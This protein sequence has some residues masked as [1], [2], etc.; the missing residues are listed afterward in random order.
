MASYTK[1]FAANSYSTIVTRT[2]VKRFSLALAGGALCAMISLFEMVQPLDR[3]LYDVIIRTNP[4]P[5]ADDIVIVAIDEGSLMEL[6]RWPWPRERHVQ[7]L[8]ELTVL[9]VKAIALDIIFSEANSDYPE[10]DQL[11][12]KAMRAHGRVLLPIFVGQTGQRTLVEVK[13]IPILAAAAADLGHVHIELDSDGASR[14]VYLFDGIGAPTW[15]HF[16]LALSRLTDEAPTELPGTINSKR[17]QKFIPKT[18]IRDYHNL[19]PFMGPADTVATIS[20]V[21]VLRGRVSKQQLQNKIVFVGATAAG[22]V[23]NLTTPLGQISGVEINAN[24][25]HALRSGLLI[26]Q[27]PARWLAVVIF[28]A[29]FF[30]IIFFT[31]LEPKALLLAIVVSCAVL[32]VISWLAL[33]WLGLWASP[34]PV[35]VSLILAYP[36]WNWSRLDAA[37]NFNHRQLRLLKQDNQELHVKAR[38]EDIERT[39]QFL[40]DL[41]YLKRWSLDK[42]VAGNPKNQGWRHA[43]LHSQCIYTIAEESRQL[44]LFWTTDS[45]TISTR[46]EE[47]FPTTFTASLSQTTDKLIQS[48]LAL[49][50]EAYSDASQNREL[51]RGTM[52]QLTTGIILCGLGGDIL[53]I[54]KQARALLASEES[55]HTVLDVLKQLELD[56]APDVKNLVSSLVINDEPFSHEGRCRA[57]ARELLCKGRLL[58]LEKPLILVTLTDVTD[59]KHSELK[60]AEALDFL[61]HDLR[62]PLTSVLALIE[63]AKQQDTG[64]VRPDVL[65]D[66]EHYIRKNLSYAEN[67]VQLSRLAHIEKPRLD[68]C[69][70]QSMVDNAVA[71]VYHSAQQQG[72]SIRVTY[73]SEDLWVKCN[74][75]FLERALINLIDNSVKYGPKGGTITV[76]LER[77]EACIKFI[78]AD[79]GPGIPPG[80]FDRIF[81]H[82]QQGETASTG[83]GLGLRFVAAVAASH[84]GDV[85]VVNLQPTGARFTLS[86]PNGFVAK[87]AD[88]TSQSIHN[89]QEHQFPSSK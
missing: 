20:Y 43:G 9:G 38:W 88:S 83:V 36:L 35:M 16:S 48:D 1:Y 28:L 24:I 50:E 19:I 33:S 7:L 63:S 60:R 10:V 52:E 5:Q 76:G 59:M 13:P 53:I 39:A 80:D 73:S 14:S 21:D 70:A 74:R 18:I 81:G 47:L 41:G 68:E 64:Q 45:E 49:L 66:I 82:F 30:T 58:F 26:Q 72:A 57:N 27:T 56:N 42:Y 85:K 29:T 77:E 4:L 40:H 17:P 69:E 25:F 79:E 15:P 8:R 54:N 65:E 55:A 51:L 67:F 62:A 71:Q 75:S 78:V 37:V 86:I 46:L 2:A 22:Q 44:Q 32:P 89:Y 31:Q 61:S 34:V 6:G 3:L 11:L 23:D 87:L 84:D 12:A